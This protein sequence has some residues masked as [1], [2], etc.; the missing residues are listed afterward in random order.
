MLKKQNTHQRIFIGGT[1]EYLLLI[2]GV[3]W[4]LIQSLLVLNDV[5]SCCE[6]QF[7]RQSSLDSPNG[8]SLVCYTCE[9]A[10]FRTK[11]KDSD[12]HWPLVCAS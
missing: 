6:S 3:I 11:Q 7:C 1:D 9:W 10:S 12:L 8:V 4:N 2:L 5:V